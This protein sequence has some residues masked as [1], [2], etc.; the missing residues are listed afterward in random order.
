MPKKVVVILTIAEA[1][2]LSYAT[3]N[4][5]SDMEY[6]MA[7]FAGRKRKV[8]AAYRGRDKLE[9]AIRAA[10]GRKAAR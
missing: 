1:I 6:A 4:T 9:E 3:D 7:C 10:G 5:L 8:E 2:E